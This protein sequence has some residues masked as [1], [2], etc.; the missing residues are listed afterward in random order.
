MEDEEEEGGGEEEA[1]EGEE[2]DL[3]LEQREVGSAGP[4]GLDNRVPGGVPQVHEGGAENIPDHRTVPEQQLRRRRRDDPD[5]SQHEI[6]SGE[7]PLKR[8]RVADRVAPRPRAS[9]VEKG[10]RASVHDRPSR[11]SNEND[12]MPP[13][14]GNDDIFAQEILDDTVSFGTDQM[15]E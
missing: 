13:E 15:P 7:S 4:G 5:T 10:R 8:Q 1:E 3:E 12:R 14:E 9:L 11:N 6:L 2:S